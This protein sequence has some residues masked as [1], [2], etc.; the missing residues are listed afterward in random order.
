MTISRQ[1]PL[2]W[3]SRARPRAPRNAELGSLLETF[4]I[5][6]A[7]TVLVVRTQLWLTHYR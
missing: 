3:W 1:A 6:A 5:A 4:L 2:T 7:T